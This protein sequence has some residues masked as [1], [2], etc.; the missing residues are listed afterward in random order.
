M[1]IILLRYT[2][3]KAKAAEYL[4]EHIAWAKQGMKDGVFLTVGTLQPNQGGGIMAHNEERS[5]LE[6]RV[7]EDPFVQQGIVEAEILEITPS[8]ADERLQFLIA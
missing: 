4:D 6:I 7:N 8:M 1:F 2:D 5:K 3:N